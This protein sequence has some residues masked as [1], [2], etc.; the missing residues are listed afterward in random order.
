MH[1]TIFALPF[2]PHV[3]ALFACVACGTSSGAGAA[4]A[5]VDGSAEAGAEGGVIGVPCVRVDEK[6]PAFAGSNEQEVVLE[7]KN[8]DCP[9]AICLLNHFRGRAT[10][11]YGQAA[12]GGAPPRS[13]PCV[14]PGTSTPVAK[15]VA[16]QCADRRAKATS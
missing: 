2:F 10:C 1:R 8:P 12:D 5:G 11:P 3:L 16:P 6:D 7:D 14:A 4:D 13:T 15:A 9:G